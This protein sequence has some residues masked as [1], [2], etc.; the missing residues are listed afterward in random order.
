MNIKFKI[1][2]N[3]LDWWYWFLTLLALIAGL[4]G[5]RDG[6]YLVILISIIQFLHFTIT[7]GFTAFP[8][9]VRF[10]YAIFVSI[11]LFDPTQIFYWLLLIGTVMVTLFNTCFIARILILMPWN[12]N[13]SLSS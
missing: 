4:S 10:V 8:T 6:F 12:K 2:L 5:F 11:A 3:S 7:K 1:N 9:Q 13:A